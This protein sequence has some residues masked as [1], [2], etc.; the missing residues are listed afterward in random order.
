M[1]KSKQGTLNILDALSEHQ[2][3]HSSVF[4]TYGADLAF[5]ENAILPTLW[6]KG[7]RRNLI[8]MDAERYA[9]TLN[10]LRGGVSKIGQRYLVVPIRLGRFQ[11]FHPKQILLLG[12]ERARLLVGSGNLTFTGYGHNHEVFTCVDWTPD[13]PEWE[14]LCIQAWQVIGTIMQKW[15]HVKEARNMVQRIEQLS[16]WLTHNLVSSSPEIQLFHSLDEPLLQQID[17]ALAGEAIRKITVFAPFLD[18]RAAAVNALY[19]YFHPKT[20]RLVLQDHHAVGNTVALEKLLKS[21]KWLKIHH[22]QQADDD[23]RYLH[24]KIY[25]FETANGVYAVT[26]SANCSQGALLSTSADGNVEI[27]F[28]RKGNSADIANLLK[29]RI[30]LQPVVNLEDMSL[31][32]ADISPSEQSGE[33][34]HLLDISVESGKLVANYTVNSLPK[35]VATL[36][37]RVS[38]TPPEFITLGPASTGMHT[39]DIALADNLQ[40]IMAR[41]QSASI[42][43][44]ADTGQSVDLDCN[45]LWITHVDILRFEMARVTPVD[46]GAGD[47]ITD[48][49]VGSE[50]EW[51]ELRETILKLVELDVN[52]LERRKGG[53]STKKS[54]EK[55]G[56][57]QN[58]EKETQVLL[59]DTFDENETIEQREIEEKNFKDSDFGRW[60]D[61][62]RA[63][64]PGA[65]YEDPAED[66]EDLEDDS[67][68]MSNP[69]EQT[70]T[71]GGNG[72][73]QKRGGHK[74][75]PSEHEGRRFTNLVRKYIASLNNDE[76][77]QI[78]SVHQK[79]SYY[80]VFQRIIW[81]LFEHQVIDAAGF[82]DFACQINT[83]LLGSPD[84]EP[85]ALCTRLRSHLRSI[86]QQEWEAYGVPAHVLVSL[87]MI[88]QL[89]LRIDDEGLT[90]QIKQ[91]AAWILAGLTS[92]VGLPRSTQ[93]NGVYTQLAE[94]YHRDEVELVLQAEET[95]KT[96]LSEINRVLDRWLQR[97]IIALE[98]TKDTHLRNLL[99]QT[100]IDYGRA[101]Y[102]ILDQMKEIKEQTNLCSNLI[103]WTRFAGDK[104][105]AHK[106]EERLISLLQ[107]QGF[108]H[109]AA[110]SLFHQGVNLFLSSEH[111]EAGTKL[112][113]ALMLAEQ[114]SDAAL[115][116]K[117]NQYLGYTAFFLK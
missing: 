98:N 72:K 60:F 104:E 82:I 53:Y 101:R 56:S 109:D 79:I 26:G 103:F 102:N 115:L 17:R 49:V 12:T 80:I 34:V 70:G 47:T 88:D 44:M 96:N 21:G 108:S 11:S 54:G 68:D 20:V 114:L 77:M 14:Y 40:K 100:R 75:T 9:D 85:P 110:E 4:L 42:W 46:I 106:Y 63:R 19:D 39:I 3:F 90:D 92:V 22:F 35:T 52:Q 1:A 81:L 2:D 117:C 61:Y 24:A 67:D 76:Y 89:S 112:N 94:W 78:A 27:V 65:G 111:K 31:R 51:R 33:K 86:W 55:S 59:V 5:F 57:G 91:Q 69:D 10:D 50:K 43:S 107:A 6:D 45:E 23:Q 66:D 83:G 93:T 36:H 28:L 32:S 16:P 97:V 64:L 15:G 30:N 13:Q 73:K 38:T 18:E 71:T 105:G 48:G 87:Y 99:L 8:I 113:Q 116:K 37:L 74:W 62:I 58:R 29:N 41:P 7:C 95:H 25:I 84:G